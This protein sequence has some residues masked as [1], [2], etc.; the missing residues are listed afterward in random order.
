MTQPALIIVNG[1]PATGKTTLA[2]RFAEEFRLPCFRKDVYKEAAY[3]VFG[4]ITP[5]QNKLLGRLAMRLLFL[6]AQE[7]LRAGSSCIVE[8]NFSSDLASKEYEELL[9]TVNARGCQV[10]VTT[11]PSVLFERF[12]ERARS[13]ERHPGH[14][15]HLPESLAVW[16]ERLSQPF[17]PLQLSVPLLTVDTTDFSTLDFPA[18][19][20]RVQETL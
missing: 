1:L 10:L 11:D 15:D 5:E 2:E 14:G 18:L 17:S 3:D 4:A 19:L 7:V 12:A 13:E 16:R 8:A 20:A 9:T 6:H